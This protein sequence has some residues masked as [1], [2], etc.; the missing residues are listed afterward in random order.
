MSLRA[1]SLA[2]IDWTRWQPQERA[3]LCF[4]VEGDGGDDPREGP[5]AGPEGGRVL[6]MRKKQGLGA[7]KIVA[8]GGRIEPGETADACAVRE[9]EEEVC[10]TP[11][12]ARC[13]GEHR[14]Q[15]LDGYAIH[16]FAYR[17]TGFTG[18]PRE[19]DEGTPLWT[20]LS[21]LPW[22][23]MWADN[24]HWLPRLFAGEPFSGRWLFDVHDLV[25]WA[26]DDRFEPPAT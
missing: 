25:D 23:E 26:I 12:G 24:V 14:F 3:T 22:D 11:T 6:L 2:D 7:G 9:V 8:P 17:A 20:P 19:T 13:V 16:V 5:A 15:F 18:E 1:S 10:V 21:A 4:V